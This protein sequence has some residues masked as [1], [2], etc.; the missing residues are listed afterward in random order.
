MEPN[1]AGFTGGPSADNNGGMA[2]LGKT[3][4]AG[5]K[6]LDLTQFEAGTS[7]TEALAWLGADVIKVEEPQKGDQGRGASTNIKGVDSHYFMLLNA[8]KRSITCN[9]KSEQGRAIFRSMLKKAD[10]VIENFGRGVI[11]KLGFGWEEIQKINPRVVFAQ[12]KGFSAESPYA[13]FLAFDMIAQATGGSISL[14]GDR[15]GR[16]LRPGVTV[17]DTGTGLHCTIGILAALFQR[18]VTGRGQHVEVAMQEAVINFARIA[19]ATQHLTGK[20][21]PRAGNQSILG[22]SSPSEN[23][24]CKGDDPNDYCFIYTSR[25][26]SLHWQRLLKVIGREDLIDDPRFSSPEARWQHRDQVDALVLGWTSQHDKREV[27]QKLG[28][29]GVPAGAVFNTEELLN[30][31]SL[32]K[33]GMFVTVDHPVRGPFTMPGFA[34]RLSDSKVPVTP[35]PLLGQH[36]EEV[37]GEWLGYT[38][39][40]VHELREEKVI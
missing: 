39:A 1:T 36:N 30:D 7:C 5:I 11:E 32:R 33:S 17:G 38:P 24:K 6:V 25:A 15:D 18:T 37:Y 3:A 26:N 28:E 20:P 29:A 9:L 4:L 2:G 12:I 23:Y 13:D 8:N 22:T 19:F 14:T 40:Q 34:V 27:M 35:S 10:V 16:P 21:V 31:P